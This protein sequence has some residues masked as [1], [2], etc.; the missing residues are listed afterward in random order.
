VKP[1]LLV[2]LL[3]AGCV[4][5]EEGVQT[6]NDSVVEK[7]D[8]HAIWP[9]GKVTLSELFHLACDSSHV[10][11]RGLGAWSDAIQVEPRLQWSWRTSK[12]LSETASDLGDRVRWGWGIWN[13]AVHVFPV[14][15]GEQSRAD[16]D[17]ALEILGNGKTVHARGRD[18][19]L[20][21]RSEIAWEEDPGQVGPPFLN[22]RPDVYVDVN[23]AKHRTEAIN[24]GA[25]N[26]ETGVFMI[27]NAR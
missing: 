24:G 18:G 13:G 19:R 14:V 5:E 21:W 22:F 10:H 23:F 12:V 4:S 11:V 20:L 1:A 6:E 2:L 15:W 25:I 8:A 3:L 9:N 26:L 16:S 7:L 17:M 27:A